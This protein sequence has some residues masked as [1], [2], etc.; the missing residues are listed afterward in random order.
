[1]ATVTLFRNTNMATVTSLYIVRTF[2]GKTDT[3]AF[4][5]QLDISK[6]KKRQGI[7]LWYILWRA[8][9]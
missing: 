7:Y 5:F 9:W 3:V 8:L 6:N 2:E 1:M 4:V